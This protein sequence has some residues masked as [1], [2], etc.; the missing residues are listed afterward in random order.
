[1]AVVIISTIFVRERSQWSGG[2]VK[3]DSVDRKTD[4]LFPGIKETAILNQSTNRIHMGYFFGL[5]FS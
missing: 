5:S 4:W 3:I 1:M 2:L